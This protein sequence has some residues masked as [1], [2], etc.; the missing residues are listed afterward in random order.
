MCNTLRIAITREVGEDRYTHVPEG[1]PPSKS[2]FRETL[3]LI[4]RRYQTRQ[5][6]EYFKKLFFC[7][8]TIWFNA[9]HMQSYEKENLHRPPSNS[10][11]CLWIYVYPATVFNIYSV[12]LT[13]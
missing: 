8:V 12:M 13:L 9:L 6:N 3:L 1:T 11:N 4:P 2:F 5:L 7:N 10:S